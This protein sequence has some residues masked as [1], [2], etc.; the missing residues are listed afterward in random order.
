MEDR[1]HEPEVDRDR[2][3]PGEQRLDA[4]LER[5]VARVHL[6]VERDHLVGELSSALAQRVHRA[7]ER[8]EH[9]LR[10]LLEGRLELAAPPGTTREAAH[11]PNRPVT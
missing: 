2:R 6:V 8:A 10:L 3:L 11:H 7:A 1:Q 9:E 4:L 5:E